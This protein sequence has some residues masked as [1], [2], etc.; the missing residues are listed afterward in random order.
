MLNPITAVAACH[1]FPA[2]EF[3]PR[4]ARYSVAALINHKSDPLR[5]QSPGI[6][7]YSHRET[8]AALPARPGEAYADLELQKAQVDR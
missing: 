8:I 2:I 6:T 7:R 5:R 1:I 3:L 4:L